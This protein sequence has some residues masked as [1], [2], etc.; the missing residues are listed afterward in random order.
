MVEVEQIAQLQAEAVLVDTALLLVSPLLRVQL[1]LFLLARVV[2]AVLKMPLTVS[3]VQ[4]LL[5]AL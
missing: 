2:M 5:L 4:I 3:T 1:T